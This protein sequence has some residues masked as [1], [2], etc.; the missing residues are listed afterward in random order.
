MAGGVA[1]A[2]ENHIW[3]TTGDDFLYGTEGSD[4]IAGLE[5]NDVIYGGGGNDYLSGGAGSDSL[6]GEA[7][8]DSVQ[9]EEGSITDDWS[10]VKRTLY[11]TLDDQRN[12]GPW[13]DDNVHSDVENIDATFALPAAVTGSAIGQ[14]LFTGNRDD[15]VDGAGG[16]DI[17]NTQGGNDTIR[18]A[19]NTPGVIDTVWCGDGNDTVIADS[20]DRVN[21]CETVSAPSDVSGGDVPP[22]PPRPR[23]RARRPTERR[24]LGDFQVSYRIDG[25]R[26]ALAVEGLESGVMVR[27]FCASGCGKRGRALTKKRSQ[28]K[29]VRL[30]IGAKPNVGAGDRI[31]IR[32]TKANHFGRYAIFRVTA[33]LPALKRLR[34][35][36]LAGGRRVQCQTAL[37][38]SGS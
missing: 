30:R 2:Q 27:A 23:R 15:T 26:A 33:S 7:G 5:G 22:E 31:E 12:D 21:G 16:A 13:G 28:G 20:D 32:A 19:D 34:S 6:H 36:C 29:T 18:V 25:R 11:V 10:G 37:N 35:G 17:V 8:T 38:A 24:S 3:G 9:F 14:S 4:S 1:V